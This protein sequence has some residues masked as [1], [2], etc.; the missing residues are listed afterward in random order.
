MINRKLIF[1][2]LILFFI[3]F[4]NSFSSDI[5]VQRTQRI[6]KVFKEHFFEV[7]EP[8]DWKYS[9]NN[10]AEEK[11]KAHRWV[12]NSNDYITEIRVAEYLVH[13][14][15]SQLKNFYSDN[16]K[17]Y[18]KNIRFRSTNKKYID[19]RWIMEAKLAGELSQGKQI[20][21]NLFIVKNRLFVYF[22]SLIYCFSK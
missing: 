15:F 16:I 13:L 18:I 11:V 17:N 19:D 20:T 2:L 22:I 5:R 12:D 3:N 8:K 10:T 7:L 21:I 14:N 9:F 1:I 6:K 4:L